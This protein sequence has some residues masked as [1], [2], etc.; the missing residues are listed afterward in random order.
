MQNFTYAGTCQSLDII[1]SIS[2]FIDMAATLCLET[3]QSSVVIF[4]FPH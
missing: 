2:L 1:C 4:P 3:P